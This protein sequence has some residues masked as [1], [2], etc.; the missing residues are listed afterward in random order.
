[1]IVTLLIIVIV[2]Q[3]LTLISNAMQFRALAV[4]WG[5]LG[6]VRQGRE[7][8]GLHG[9]ASSVKSPL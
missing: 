9:Y 4:V 8:P 1:M 6:R 3:V 5:P 7:P 2:L